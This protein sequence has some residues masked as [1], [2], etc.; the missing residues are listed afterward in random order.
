[1]AASRLVTVPSSRG[2][3]NISAGTIS[4]SQARSNIGQCVTVEGRAAIHADELRAGIDVDMGK[5]SFTFL[6]F[7]PNE[8]LSEF[9][10]LGSHAG[11]TVDITGVIQWY[12]GRPEI[13]MTS[14]QQL[15]L[16]PAGNSPHALL[17]C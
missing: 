5:D 11:K 9:P 13:K 3:S 2:R 16:V 15:Q 6:G 12:R 7:I 10:N 4:P 1:V 17:R 14:K 8:N